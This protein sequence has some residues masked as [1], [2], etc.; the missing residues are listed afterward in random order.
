MQ[1][2]EKS[3]GSGALL[4]GPSDRA[5]AQRIARQPR[6]SAPR[7]WGGV[8]LGHGHAASDAPVKHR[9]ATLR[10]L[11]PRG[12]HEVVGL[13]QLAAA[14][15]A[16]AAAATLLH[17]ERLRRVDQRVD[18]LEVVG[19]LALAA[20]TSL[21]CTL[22]TSSTSARFLRMRRLSTTPLS[23]VYAYATPTDRS[24][25]LVTAWN[26]AGSL[27]TPGRAATCGR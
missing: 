10:R 23:Y 4:M 12:G 11:N 25:S 22:P 1:N 3:L 7:R 15:A 9:L 19:R 21:L 16:R 5:E 2:N 24:T 17:L 6:R 20:P 13:G 27:S 26:T 8:R 18:E 14:A